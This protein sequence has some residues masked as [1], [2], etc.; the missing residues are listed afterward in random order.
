MI[1][2]AAVRFL[3]EDTNEWVTIPCHR[4]HDAYKIMMD[5]NIPWIRDKSE[6]GFLTEKEEFLERAAALDVAKECN[7]IKHDEPLFGSLLYSENLW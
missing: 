6:Q 3:R 1:T 5:L 2:K 4:H 7:Q